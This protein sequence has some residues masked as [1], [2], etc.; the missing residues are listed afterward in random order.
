[1]TSGKGGLMP[2]SK[3]P[4]GASLTAPLGVLGITGLT[5]Y[6]GLLDLG[7]PKGG[8]TVCRVRG[9]RRHRLYCRADRQNQGLPG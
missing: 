6:F 4:A 9:G 3:I 5:A 2:A 8:E 1:M 7:Q